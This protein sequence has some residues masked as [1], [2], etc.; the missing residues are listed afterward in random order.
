MRRGLSLIALLIAGCSREP[1]ADPAVLASVDEFKTSRARYEQQLQV[2]IAAQPAGER[3]FRGRTLR[4]D[5]ERWVASPDSRQSI[6]ALVDRALDSR[7]PADARQYLVQAQSEL[8]AGAAHTTAIME[9]WQRHL[10]APYWRRYWRSLFEANGAAAETP[11]PMLVSIEKRM[12]AAM[13]KGDFAAASRDASDLL[14]VFETA[15]DRVTNRFAKELRDSARYQ[16]RKSPCVQGP[17]AGDFSEHARIVRGESID[18]FYPAK[19][20]SSGEQGSVVLRARIVASGC[21]PEVAVVVHS[22]VPSLDTAA[23]QWFESAQFSPATEHGVPI[24]SSLVWK[25]RFVLKD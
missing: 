11:D 24:E 9:Y 19:A 5:L 8:T 4:E 17:A 16:A 15:R 22:G 20:I 18:K 2:W 23:L 21:A 14:A 10:P 6:D 7:Y 13:D 1:P 12:T 25:V 3:D